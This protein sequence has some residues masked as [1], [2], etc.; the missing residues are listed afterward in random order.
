MRQRINPTSWF[1]RC[2]K[3]RPHRPGR[4]RKRRSYSPIAPW[5]IANAFDIASEQPVQLG[6]DQAAIGVNLLAGRH[7]DERRCAD[8]QWL[9]S[10]NGDVNFSSPL[11]HSDQLLPVLIGFVDIGLMCVSG[12]GADLGEQRVDGGNRD[13]LR[14]GRGVAH[15]RHRHGGEV[16]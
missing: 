13:G 15:A 9:E 4:R 10:Q 5:R 6:Q 16:R 7:S 12:L 2:K 11:A 3:P 8:V 14:Q 1:L